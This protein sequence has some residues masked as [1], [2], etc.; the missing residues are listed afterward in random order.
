MKAEPIQART[1]VKAGE[2][3]GA[4]G[5][6]R[7]G[8]DALAAEFRYVITDMICRAGSGHL[9]G[10]LSLVEIAITLYYRVMN[11]RPRAPRW[12]DRDRLVVSKGHAGPVI[13]A[14]L[15]YR[16][17]FPR[18]WLSTLNADGTR[19]PS[20]MD[21]RQTPGVDMTAGSLGQGLSC[22]CG[23][24]LAARRD[25][26]SCTTYCIIGD[27][28]S[29]EGQIW[30]AALF[31]AHNRMDNLVA[32]CDYNKL[33]ID[34]FTRDVLELEPLADKWRAFGWA[35]FETDGHDWD[36]V[37]DTLMAAKAVRGKP[38]MI[39]AHT[40]KGKGNVVVENMPESHNVKVP[41]SEAYER[42]MNGLAAQ[43]FAL[44][45]E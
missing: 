2:P 36:S 12:P 43:G 33:Q 10:A 29:N 24:A 26:R 34:G 7:P 9:G 44:P 18:S 11:I 17:F 28:E 41:D 4:A 30:E 3:A 15:A 8:Y 35:V 1:A 27:G 20:H 13:Y 22:A 14:A 25:N 38:A 32:I 5:V 39:I 23:I 31:A 21:M 37:Y 40:I 16:G 45:Y 6:D 19:L 42:Y